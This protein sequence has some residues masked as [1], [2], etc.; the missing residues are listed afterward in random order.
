MAGNALAVIF[1]TLVTICSLLFL[2]GVLLRT[3]GPD[4][5][6]LWSLVLATTSVSRLAELG[7]SRG[8]VK[9]VAQHYA[10]KDREQAALTIETS[11]VSM[12]VLM[13]ALAPF[14]YWGIAFALRHLLSDAL[15]QQAIEILPL[16]LAS[17]W[18]TCIGGVFQSGLDAHQRFD[19][20]AAVACSG[21]IM[22][23]AL[24]ILA[25]K[26]Y[27]LIGLAVAQVIQA[28]WLLALSCWILHR[29]L[30]EMSLLPLRW[31]RGVFREIFGYSTTFQASSFVQLLFEPATKLLLSKYAGVGTVAYFEMA[32]RMIGQAR[33]LLVAA[34]QV[35]V[36][37]VADL[38]ERNPSGLPRMYARSVDLMTSLSAI[39][40]SALA[41]AIPVITQL[42]VGRLEPDFVLFANLLLVA[43]W[44]NSLSVPAY[45]TYLGIGKLRWNFLGHVLTGL[46]NLLLGVTLGRQFGA[47]GVVAGMSMALVLG[48][49]LSSI[50]FHW[51]HDL[52]WREILSASTI[53]LN[54]IGFAALSIGIWLSLTW[55]KSATPGVSKMM[56]TTAASL[57]VLALTVFW[58][59]R[60]SPTLEFV[61]QALIRILR[62]GKA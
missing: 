53:R 19:L 38:M 61:R 28:A 8:V 7:F 57:L 59:T 60:G 29:L 22:F 1:Q 31:R 37:A 10:R 24:A 4:T 23:C 49:A 13:A 25:V 30:P 26:Q 39:F 15:Y 33:A 18:L 42:W 21:Q 6:G 16:S 55:S 56:V 17:L 5:L 44:I 2:Y 35:L 41:L 14:A 52:R 50:A 58:A 11:V 46:L 12:A 32:S 40:F 62:P 54:L 45:H 20:R 9:F 43:W 48:S 34:S 3:L 51:E 47:V 27:G 36:P